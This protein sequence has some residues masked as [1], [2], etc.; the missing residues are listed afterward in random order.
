MRN[1]GFRVKKANK[2]KEF[3]ARNAQTDS[4]TRR[5][6]NVLARLGAVGEASV[7]VGVVAFG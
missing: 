3:R 7:L 1:L 2:P 6:A 5:Y 4:Q